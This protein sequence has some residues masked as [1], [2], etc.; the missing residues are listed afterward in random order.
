MKRRSG[1]LRRES[2][3]D[4]EVV[5][6][7]VSHERSVSHMVRVVAAEELVEVEVGRPEEKSLRKVKHERVDVGGG[8]GLGVGSEREGNEDGQDYEI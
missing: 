4:L 2:F 7:D 8:G 1:G 3:F 5:A 6:E